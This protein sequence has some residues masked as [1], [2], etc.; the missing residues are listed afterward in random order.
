LTVVAA[1]AFAAH[2]PAVL[3]LFLYAFQSPDIWDRQPDPSVAEPDTL[4]A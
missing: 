1:I 2:V 4:D 3:G